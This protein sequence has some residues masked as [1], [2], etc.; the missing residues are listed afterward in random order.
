VG[1]GRQEEGQRF[2]RHEDQDG[3]HRG[4]EQQ[5]AAADHDPG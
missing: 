5:P 4:D 3:E 1:R 2:A